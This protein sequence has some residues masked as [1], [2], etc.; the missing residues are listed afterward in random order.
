MTHA[1][2]TLHELHLL[3]IYLHDGAVRVGIAVETYDEAVA[4]RR[5]L[6]VVSYARHWA[7]GRY[8]VAEVV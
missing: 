3:L 2:A 6:M 4:Q 8:D 5:Y 1:A 7:T